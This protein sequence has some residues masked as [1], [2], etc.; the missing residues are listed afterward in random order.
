TII[1]TGKLQPHESRVLAERLLETIAKPVVLQS[2]EVAVSA[3]IGV[4]IYPSDG[5]SVD[6][7]LRNAGTAMSGAKADGKGM[8]KFFEP[9]RNRPR[10][11]RHTIEARLRRA[12][13]EEE[14]TVAYQ[15]VVDCRTRRTIGFEALVR[16]TDA[17]LGR[18]SPTRFIPI[19]EETG[20]IVPLGEY[21]LRTA[22]RDATR[23]HGR[24]RVGVNLSATQFRRPGLPDTVAKILAETGL[25]GDR[26]DL[27]ITESIVIDNR[28]QVL[29]TLHALKALGIRV[30]MDD[31]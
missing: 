2:G 11:A 4:A 17:T 9:R 25:P 13:A 26:L 14:L 12:I 20:L 6:E 15:P 7:V 21:V 27:E 22:C 3:S 16:W 8:F 28:A 29:E 24:L 5:R 23:W 19:A 18:V 10:E 1:A 30:S 31:F